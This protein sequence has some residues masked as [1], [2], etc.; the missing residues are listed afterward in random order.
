MILFWSKWSP[1]QMVKVAEYQMFYT[2]DED[3]NGADKYLDNLVVLTLW[4]CFSWIWIWGFANMQMWSEWFCFV[5]SPDFRRWKYFTR[6]CPGF[7]LE[8][9]VLDKY[10]TNWVFK[11]GQTSIGNCDDDDYSEFKGIVHN[12]F[13]YRSNLIFWIVM[14]N[15]VWYSW[16]C[17]D[18]SINGQNSTFLGFHFVPRDLDSRRRPKSAIP[19]PITIQNMRFEQ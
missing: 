2:D 10:L 16:L 5:Y 12:F 3:R 18:G 13:V 11:W 17:P 6:V 19:H 1:V 14:G 4:L 15:G 9:R 8:E 7:G